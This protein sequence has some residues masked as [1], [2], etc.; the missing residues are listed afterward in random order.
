MKGGLIERLGLAGCRLAQ[1]QLALEQAGGAFA[2][3]QSAKG[4]RCCS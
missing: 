4:V 2:T 1:V 3:I